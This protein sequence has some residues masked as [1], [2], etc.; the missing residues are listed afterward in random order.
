MFL[1]KKKNKAHFRICYFFHV[2][3][4]GHKKQLRFYRKKKWLFLRKLNYFQIKNEEIQSKLKFFFKHQFK[5]KIYHKHYIRIFYGKL[6]DY[7]IRNLYHKSL[8]SKIPPHQKFIGFL[9]RRLEIVLYRMFFFRSIFQIKQ[10]IR[11][12]YICVNNQIIKYP[13][14]YLNIGD[15]VT[16]NFYKTTWYKRYA[17]ILRFFKFFENIK[18]KKKKK[19]EF[20]FF[21]QYLEINF[22]ILCGILYQPPKTEFVYF[23]GRMNLEYVRRSYF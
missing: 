15:I 16:F 2:N 7:Q 18:K 3:I 5:S 4:W 9:E 10:F 22:N 17:K 13:N 14:F 1:N 8:Q 19:I 20:F 6:K 11:C 23:K 12:G 21:P